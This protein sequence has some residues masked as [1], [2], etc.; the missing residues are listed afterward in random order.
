M[1][2]K[3]CESFEGTRI[4]HITPLL[5]DVVRSK[6]FKQIAPDEPLTREALSSA[7]HEG[8]DA[9]IDYVSHKVGP[10]GFTMFHQ[11]NHDNWIHLFGVG[12]G[13][14]LQRIILG[15]PLIAITMLE[16]DLYSGLFVP[17]E[18]L[19]K[20]LADKQGTEIVYVLPSSLIAGV[21][22]DKKLEGAAK[23]LDAKLQ[24]L[25]VFATS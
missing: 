25:V 9:Y 11:F 12:G 5:F 13:L 1:E 10:L 18:M 3:K 8:K 17:V 15:N 22:S 16:H 14:R 2:A 19:L 23:V 7:A 21:N 24:D 6:L 20:E 4:T